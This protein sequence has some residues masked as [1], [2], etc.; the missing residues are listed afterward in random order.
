MHQ[1]DAVV[2]REEYIDNHFKS[3]TRFGDHALHHLFPTLDDAELKTLYPTLLSHCE[4]YK[5][6]LR[7]NTFYEA[8]LSQAKQLARKGPNDFA[9]RKNCADS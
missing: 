4:I 2:E 3:L 6:E 8:L 5:T 7:T 1:L 9:N